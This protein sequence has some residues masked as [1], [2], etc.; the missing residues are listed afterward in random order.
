[1]NWKFWQKVTHPKK[2]STT[3]EVKLMKPRELPERVG[4]YLVTKLKLDPDWVWGLK[5]VMRPKADKKSVFEIRIFNPVTA[6]G[7]GVSVSNFNTLDQYP[8][9]ILFHGSFNKNTGNI[10]MEKTLEKV[11]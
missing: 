10:D 4:M 7:K 11:A 1:M 6:A 3:N 5:C 2:S 8:D 9:L